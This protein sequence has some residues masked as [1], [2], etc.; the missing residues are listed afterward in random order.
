M[1]S[2]SKAIFVGRSTAGVNE[3]LP[4]TSSSILNRKALLPHAASE[5]AWRWVA[6]SLFAVRPIR[7][8][9]YMRR[10][11]PPGITLMRRRSR[12]GR[13]IGFFSWLT[14]VVIALL[15]LSRWRNAANRQDAGRA[16]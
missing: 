4:L 2:G 8:P 5:L 9:R 1:H 10:L 3:T 14:L 6:R 11:R 12:I 13:L 7:R 15:F 16:R